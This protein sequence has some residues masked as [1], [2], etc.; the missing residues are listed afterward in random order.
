MEA[1]LVTPLLVLL[2]LVAVGLGRTAS[3]RLEVNS[4]ARQAAR[5]ASLARDAD[6]AATQARSTAQAA[7]AE[8]GV[9]CADLRVTVDTADF[10][11]GGNVTVALSCTTRLADVAM[12]GLPGRASLQG[13][14]V[15]P[16]DVYRS[17]SGDAP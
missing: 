17:V 6:T 3:T 2:A 10:T 7:L 5:A 1:A 4:A 13:R 14:F 12:P 11:P 16:V 15:S 9:T 8:D